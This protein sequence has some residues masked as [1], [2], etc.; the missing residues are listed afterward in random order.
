MLSML[1]CVSARTKGYTH[2]IKM[3]DHPLED[4]RKKEED[5]NPS[6]LVRKMEVVGPWNFSPRFVRLIF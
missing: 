2:R 5:F 3:T 1:S 6:L 4:E